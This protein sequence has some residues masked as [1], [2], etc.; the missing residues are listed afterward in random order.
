M[1]VPK[2]TVVAVDAS[3]VH[4]P[5]TVSAVVFLRGS[6]EFQP[7]DERLPLAIEK[8]V[9]YDGNGELVFKAKLLRDMG[10]G[11]LLLVATI[12]GIRTWMPENSGRI[13]RRSYR[14]Y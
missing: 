7:E 10:F 14:H 11:A 6:I 3:K 8:S 12:T 9:V 13:G 1:F 4:D 5:L 2:G